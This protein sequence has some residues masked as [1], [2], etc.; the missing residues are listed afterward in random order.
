MRIF[1][2]KLKKLKKKGGKPIKTKTW[3]NYRS[4]RDG[5][6]SWQSRAHSDGRPHYVNRGSSSN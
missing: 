5:G 4:P 2:P 3:S 6:Y 1:R